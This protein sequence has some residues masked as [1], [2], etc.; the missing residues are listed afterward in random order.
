MILHHLRCIASICF[1]QHSPFVTQLKYV[2]V[3]KEAITSIGI[4]QTHE[5][6]WVSAYS[7]RASCKWKQAGVQEVTG[8]D[9]VI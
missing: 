9:R 8:T 4:A 7:W 2:L 6:V 1:L 3:V 5:R